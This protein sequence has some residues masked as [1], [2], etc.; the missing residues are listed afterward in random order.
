MT[1]PEINLIDP[2]IYP[3]VVTHMPVRLRRKP[4]L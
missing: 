4:N 3:H 2:D 1:A